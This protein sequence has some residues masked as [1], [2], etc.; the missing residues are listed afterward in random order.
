[1]ASSSQEELESLIVRLIGDASSYQQMLAEAERRAEEAAK[2][3]E[4]EGKK[5]EGV[6]DR[7]EKMA[8]GLAVAGAAVSAVFAKLG[9]EALG[10]WHTAEIT[11][12]QL[13]AT[14]RANGRAVEDLAEDYKE[15]AS[16][17]Q[18]VSRIGD[19]TTLAL[20]KQ[21]ETFDLTG[22]AAKKA[23]SD[24]NAFAVMND[25]SADSMIR[26][27]AA[28]AKGDIETAMMFSR[29]VPQLRGV[30]DEYEFL[31]RY[32]KLV[33]A[34]MEVEAKATATYSGQ[35]EQLKNAFGDYQEVIGK[36]LSE[37]L[38]PF[39]EKQKEL[40]LWLQKQP[41]W[42]H[43]LT[44]GIISLGVATGAA[45]A[46][47]SASILVWSK[48]GETLATVATRSRL[49]KLA[50]AALV[51]VILEVAYALSG[52]AKAAEDFNKALETSDK[53]WGAIL[54]KRAKVAEAT[55]S[56]AAGDPAKLAVETE[57]AVAVM[58][59][60]E[61]ALTSAKKAA[62]EAGAALIDNPLFKASDIPLWGRGE[63]AEK[64]AAKKAVE[65]AQKA[66]DQAKAFVESLK[67]AGAD[68]SKKIVDDVVMGAAEGLAK[69]IEK[70]LELS[71]KINELN[72][73]LRIQ[74]QTLGMTAEEAQVYRLK[75]EG[76][77]AADLAATEALIKQKKARDAAMKAEADAKQVI[78][79][80]QT[81]L[82]E[83]TAR[84]DFLADL[85]HKNKLTL[86]QYNRAVEMARQKLDQA[87]ASAATASREVGK[88]DAVLAGSAEAKSRLIAYRAMLDMSASASQG[89]P[90][91]SPAAPTARTPSGA[92]ASAPTRTPAQ[93]K[94]IM[95][96]TRIANGIDTI[97]AKPMVG[98]AGI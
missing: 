25:T 10:E 54:E 8:A 57:K 70:G 29:M 48:F 44:A 38:T 7:V 37:N 80:I 66:L 83:Y 41:Q 22:E 19:D 97:V 47:A 4:E 91:G 9:H 65:E 45:L 53:L 67:K 84:V 75:L 46:A 35:M 93:D 20:L 1:M 69:G 95:L 14:L 52:G 60:M 13:E 62:E 98:L 59:D 72:K 89:F 94:T 74:G 55:L 76:A 71:E 40:S 56:E 42:V 36:A 30:K 12:I 3:A 5:I 27:T 85:Y 49:A 96:L 87:G 39:V 82:E 63:A 24:A 68:A 78:Q 2:K 6:K 81:P 64:E 79:E 58:H 92:S 15:W 73:E 21:A 33:A 23:V 86:D 31:A 61:R 28:V 32:Q 88:L 90:L 26:L 51:V 77:T 34:G 43:S 50:A 18:E 11:A 16:A 17:L